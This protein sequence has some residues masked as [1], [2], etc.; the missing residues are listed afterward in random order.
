MRLLD[1]LRDL[2][3]PLAKGYLV[4]AAVLVICAALLTLL[5][6]ILSFNNDPKDNLNYLLHNWSNKF[7]F[8]IPFVW[9]VLIGHLFL[10]TSDPWIVDQEVLVLVIFAGLVVVLG[11]LSRFVKVKQNLSAW[12]LSFLVAGALYGHFFWSMTYLS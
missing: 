9:G 5:D 3:G 1:L 6:L 7:L 12:R 4:V 2:D 10:G 11:V 8:A